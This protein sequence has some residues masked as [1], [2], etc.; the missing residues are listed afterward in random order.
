MITIIYDGSY[1]NL[2]AAKIK[3]NELL[4]DD[5]F[6]ELIAA[7]DGFDFTKATPVQIAWKLNKTHDIHANLHDT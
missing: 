5:K 6:Y 3:A 1:E 2:Q 7:K 4:N